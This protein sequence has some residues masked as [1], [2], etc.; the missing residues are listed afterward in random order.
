MEVVGPFAD[1]QYAIGW[2]TSF[3]TAWVSGQA[4]LLAARMPRD[5]VIPRI[6][7]TADSIVQANDGVDLGFGRINAARSLRK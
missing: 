3:S 7:T 4:A 6:V 1:R 5:R 2:G